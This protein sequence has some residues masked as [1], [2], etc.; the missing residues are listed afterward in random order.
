MKKILVTFLLGM[1]PV[2]VMA[3]GTGM[4][5]D[6]VEI[7]LENKSSLQRGAKLFVN[8]CLSCHAAAG[9]RF[10]RVGADLGLTDDQL[11]ENL[12]FTTEKSGETMTVAMTTEKAKKWF[13]TKVP[14]LTAI[15]RARGADWLYTYLRTFYVDDTRPYG[16]NNQRFP[17][18]GMPHVLW[19]LEGLKKPMYEIKH[20]QDG[21]E[22]KVISGFETVVP[23]T[24]S[25]VEY[26]DA[27]RDLVNF[28]VYMSE[29][30]RLQRAGI[31]IGVMFFLVILL[32]VTYALKKEYW[33]D[34]H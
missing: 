14:D 26:D 8:Y 16:V 1:L 19:E 9:M 7:N 12:M 20:G 27:M 28:M 6:R 13:G 17:N 4:S 5:N 24:M 23:G 33:R 34:V 21:S 11:M 31:G 3:G 15:A 18:V 25:K 29:P 30:A 22:E 2:I 32:I 10:N